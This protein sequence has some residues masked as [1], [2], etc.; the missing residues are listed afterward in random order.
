[1]QSSQRAPRVKASK[2]SRST[3]SGGAPGPAMSGCGVDRSPLHPPREADP[4]RRWE[5]AVRSLASSL[6][7]DP[8][9]AVE[10][11]EARALARH[12]AGQ[13]DAAERA[14]EDVREQLSREAA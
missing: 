12:Y 2:P 5:H 8:R 6:G 13:A 7:A 10:E 11:F 4:G 3:S 14:F 1:M 9:L